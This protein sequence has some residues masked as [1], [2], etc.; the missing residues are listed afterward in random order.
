MLLPGSKE[1]DTWSLGALTRLDSY[2]LA[3]TPAKEGVDP[4][5]FRAALTEGG[6]AFVDLLLTQNLGAWWHHCLQVNGLL[7]SLPRGVADALQQARMAAAARYLAQRTALIHIDQLFEAAGISYAVMKG[8]HV[9]ECAYPDPSLRLTGDIDVLVTA[10]DRRCAAHA[11]LDAGY[12]VN[13]DLAIISHEA[14]FTRSPVE[15]DL[16]WDIMRPGRTRADMT[17]GL[18][19]RRRR[20]NGFWGLSDADALFLMLTHPAFAK[21]VCSPNMGLPR[22]ADFLLR[23]QNRT[24]DWPAVMR[25]LEVA[26]LRTAAWTMLNWFR[27]LAAPAAGAII[28]GWLNSLRPG[29]LRAH[30]LRRWLDH[31]LP[32]RWLNRPL[33]IQLGLTLF[34]HDRFS[35][36][37]HAAQGWLHSRRNRGRDLRLLLGND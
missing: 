13:A 23:I 12:S 11:L 15:I 1:N 6:P 2:R 33:L 29:G 25:L 8:A 5:A 4:A 30:Y 9:R 7:E 3:L 32:S 24:I 22:V 34:L 36:T 10:P 27:M 18:L 14:C 19:A 35:D 17:A 20:I 28:D 21:Y 31:D 16:H 37:L 26:G